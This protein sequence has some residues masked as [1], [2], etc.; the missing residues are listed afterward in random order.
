MSSNQIPDEFELINRYFA[1][2]AD[3]E[4]GAFGLSDDAAVLSP[5]P[6]RKL[7]FTTDGLIAGVHFFDDERPGD[8]AARL[9]GVNLSDLAAMGARPWVYTLNIAL[10]N[11]LNTD[12]IASFTRELNILQKWYKVNLIGGDTT[13][14]PGPLTL[15]LTAIG[16]VPKEGA[17][18]RSTAGNEELI[19]VSGT[20]G[21]AALGLLVLQG[22]IK[23]LNK[24]HSRFLTTRYHRPE[25][26][27]TLG[28]KLIGLANAAT[29][30]SDGLIA[31]LGHLAKASTLSAEIIINQVPFSEAAKAAFLVD[32]NLREIALTGGD[33][34]ELIF[35]VPTKKVLKVKALAQSLDLSLSNIG[36]FTQNIK[37]NSDIVRLLG[38]NGQKTKFNKNGYS[39]F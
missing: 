5:P 19:F 27:I 18:L 3:L 9:I 29:D 28:Q 10:P 17:L 4:K 12:W 23:G 25:P 1:P 7:V 30:I 35:S 39:H 13:A 22:K 20:I 6:D 16:T 36:Y 38:A 8:I 14:T 37:K 24:K 11:N 21:D 26:R 15:S 31:D 34:Y 33:D 2:L 32:K